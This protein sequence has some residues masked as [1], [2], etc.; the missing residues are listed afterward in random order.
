MIELLT[1]KYF[2]IGL[3]SLVLGAVSLPSAATIIAEEIEQRNGALALVKRTI[4]SG[5]VLSAGLKVIG[6][7]F[8]LHGMEII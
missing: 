6:V 1:N 2:S 5:F 4:S 8:I 3:L 7:L